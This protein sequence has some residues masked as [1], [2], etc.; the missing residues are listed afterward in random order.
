V[1]DPC[2]AFIAAGT[3]WMTRFGFAPALDANAVGM[4]WC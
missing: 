3:L 2:C 4:V 1:A